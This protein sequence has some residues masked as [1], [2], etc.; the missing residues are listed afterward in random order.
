MTALLAGAVT[1]E[2]T[3]RRG[4]PMTTKLRLAQAAAV[5]TYKNTE[6]MDWWKL[7][8]DQL[9]LKGWPEAGFRDAKDNY[10]MGQSPETAAQELIVQWS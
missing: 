10:E 4:Y 6:F 5:P 9:A 2:T 7:L 8:N 3:N 1:I